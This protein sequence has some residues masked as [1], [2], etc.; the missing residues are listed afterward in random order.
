VINKNEGGLMTSDT[1]RG[2]HATHSTPTTAAIDATQVSHFLLTR[3]NVRMPI[4]RHP[5]DDWLP[6]R[7]ELFKRY[8]LPSF[9]GQT[10][11]TFTWLVFLDSDSPDWLRTTIET[12]MSDIVHPVYVDGL[13]TAEYAAAVVAELA[14][15]PFVMTTRVDNDDAVATDFV[16]TIQREFAGQRLEFVNLVNG[17][18]YADEKVYLRPYTKNPF[19]T[20][21]ESVTDGPPKTVFIKR[22]YEVDKVGPV[23]NVR[24]EHPMW[25]QVVH[26]ENV[27]TE[28]VGLRAKPSAVLPH[29]SCTLATDYSS[30]GYLVDVSRDAVRIVWRLV[31]QPHRIIELAR[32]ATARRSG[33]PIR[34]GP[35]SSR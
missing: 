22:H 26:G 27:L 19:L 18:Q 2:S 14:T 31:E 25:L 7:L 32:T 30:L 24:T 1:H 16:E 28:R 34:V 35:I 10:V 15:T 5:G 4:Y 29:F 3:F 13:F 12:T 8:C 20:L 17:A 9:R 21:I 11:Q 6:G 23:R 33:R